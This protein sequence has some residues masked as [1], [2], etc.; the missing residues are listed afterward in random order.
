MGEEKAVPVDAVFNLAWAAPPLT[1]STLPTH[2][3]EPGARTA[4]CGATIISLGGRWSTDPAVWVSTTP[5]CPLCAA[6]V[7]GT[8]AG[9]AALVSR[10]TVAAG[11]DRWPTADPRR[12]R[13][14]ASTDRATGPGSPG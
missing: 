9:V 1:N 7:Y 3:V 2:A 4:A 11:S 13:P 8:W 10:G 6:V 12:W 5:C 14:D